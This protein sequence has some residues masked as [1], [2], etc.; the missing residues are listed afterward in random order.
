MVPETPRLYV[1]AGQSSGKSAQGLLILI[2]NLSHE[3]FE[4]KFQRVVLN[5]APEDDLV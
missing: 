4:L 3:G 1:R 5:V 2:R